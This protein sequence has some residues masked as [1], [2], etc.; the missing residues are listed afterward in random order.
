VSNLLALEERHRAL[1]SEAQRRK[2]LERVFSS[3]ADVLAKPVS[4]EEDLFLKRSILHFET[5]WRLE[6]I[7][8][9]RELKPLALDAA[10]FFSLPLPRTVWEKTCRSGK[11]V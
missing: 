2:D 1:W 3:N 10:E 5:G 11:I 7:L 4:V 6:R 9:R 8:E